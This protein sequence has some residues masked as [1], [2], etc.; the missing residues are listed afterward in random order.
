L[1][2]FQALG[3][4]RNRI[5]FWLPTEHK[6]HLEHVKMVDIALDTIPYTGGL[7]TVESLYMGV[8]V[9]GLS[10][11]LLCHRHSTSH[12]TITGHEE[13]IAASVEQYIKL[14]V[15]LA[16]D[17]ERIKKYRRD[18]RQDLI[19]SPLLEHKK[20]TSDLIKKMVALVS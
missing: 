6:E 9:I 2:K 3:V 16:E 19:K 7:T 15:E 18:L 8:P 14:A 17:S 1:D 11:R 4:D 10:G 20:F 13:L 12:L 5:G